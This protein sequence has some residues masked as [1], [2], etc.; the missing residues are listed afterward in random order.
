MKRTGHLKL[1][2]KETYNRICKWKLQPTI[3]KKRTTRQLMKI[4]KSKCKGNCVDQS[5]KGN[6]NLVIMYISKSITKGNLNI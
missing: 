3:K 5:C 2:R 6:L 4:T 1:K